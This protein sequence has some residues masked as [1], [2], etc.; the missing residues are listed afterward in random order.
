MEIFTNIKM[1]KK[2][3]YQSPNLKNVNIFTSLVLSIP[4]PPTSSFF[5]EGWIILK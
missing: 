3:I 5:C 4:Y 1:Q 2:P